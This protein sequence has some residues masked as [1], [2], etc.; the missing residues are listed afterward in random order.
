LED[1]YERWN[2]RSNS[3][4]APEILRFKKYYR[5]KKFEKIAG[6]FDEK[7][8]EMFSLGVMIFSA[9]FLRSPISSET[10]HTEDKYYKY[11]YT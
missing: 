10:A 8:S 4:L 2:N 7:K 5:E 3:A 1:F 9:F 11:F 6:A